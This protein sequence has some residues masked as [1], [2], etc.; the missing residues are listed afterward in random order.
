M[1]RLD[2]A[3]VG[4]T[5]SVRFN[6]LA[7]EFVPGFGDRQLWRMLTGAILARDESEVR[8]HVA[9]ARKPVLVEKREHESKRR[10]RSNSGDLSQDCRLRVALLG[11]RLDL[12]VLSANLFG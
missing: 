2:L 4:H 10:Q 12:F 3:I 1:K 6:Q 5:V 7:K 9:A 11:E 8:S